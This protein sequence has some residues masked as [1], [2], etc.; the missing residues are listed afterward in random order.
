MG[1]LDF[2]LKV[3][4]PYYRVITIGTSVPA[5]CVRI[6]MVADGQTYLLSI[7][8]LLVFRN[9][10][11]NV[12]SKY[13]YMYIV[14]PIIVRTPADDLSAPLNQSA[15]VKSLRQFSSCECLL[16]E[17]QS[18]KIRLVSM[19]LCIRGSHAAYVQRSLCIFTASLFDVQ[20]RWENERQG[21][22]E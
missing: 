16:R 14:F 7:R 19:C 2:L 17:V 12:P 21:T 3:L 4:R 20:I 13:F 18:T 5:R 1:P 15:H 6:K 8:W 10:V 9:V 22:H 11:V